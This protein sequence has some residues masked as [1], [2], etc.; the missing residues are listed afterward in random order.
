MK[1]KLIIRDDIQRARAIEIIRAT[2]EDHEV[3]I[4]PHK[5]KRSLDQ[6]AKMWAMLSD[7][8]RQVEWY[9]RH[10]SPEDWKD[11]FTA[12]LKRLDVVPGIEGGFVVIGA[13]TSKM[14]VQ[15]MADM[16][17]CIYAFGSERDVVWTE[18]EERKGAK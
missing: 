18:P 11:V 10:L 2:P 6:N 8:S 16:I 12:A 9:G 17:E 7:V 5:S 1:Y 15:E 3:V 4:R 13:H 14:S